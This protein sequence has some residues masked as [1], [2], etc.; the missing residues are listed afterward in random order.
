MHGRKRGEIVNWESK[1]RDSKEYKEGR[2][3][4]WG[5]QGER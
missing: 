2:D 4:E 3:S 1:V 5:E